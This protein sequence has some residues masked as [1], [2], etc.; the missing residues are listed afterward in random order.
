MAQ[1]AA[2]HNHTSCIKPTVLNVLM[3]ITGLII[4]AK[5]ATA[6][7]LTFK[8]S[9][10]TTQVPPAQQA[11]AFSTDVSRTSNLLKTAKENMYAYALHPLLWIVQ[12]KHANE[13]R[14][15]DLYRLGFY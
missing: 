4:D 3:D 15:I 2:A 10:K 14:S 5:N 7:S 9:D 6:H 1:T 13:V 8:F 12:H 11:A